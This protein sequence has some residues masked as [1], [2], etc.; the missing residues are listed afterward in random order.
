LNEDELVDRVL[1]EV[2]RLGMTLERYCAYANRH[3]ADPHVRMRTTIGWMQV[4]MR[5][6]ASRT[7]H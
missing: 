4:V 2:G 6:L 5:N 3:I 7:R 1:A